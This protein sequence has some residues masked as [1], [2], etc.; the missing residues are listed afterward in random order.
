MNGD[1][2]TGTCAYLLSPSHR[3]ALGRLA[4]Y[5]DGD[6]FAACVDRLHAHPE[7]DRRFDVIWDV[8][9]VDVLDIS[10]EGLQEMVRAQTNDA[11]GMD[12]LVADRET[13]E[14][15]LRLYAR[16]V[17]RYGRPSSVCETLDEAVQQVG[18]SQLPEA[19]LVES[20]WESV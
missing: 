2:H 13:R 20:R 14:A 18:F 12:V 15:V 10:P 16:L 4:G 11:V 7:W 9:E 5:V 3:L 6:Y 8:T 1:P 19:F 17:E